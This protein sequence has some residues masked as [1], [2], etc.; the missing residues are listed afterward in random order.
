MTYTIPDIIDESSADISQHDQL[1]RKALVEYLSGVIGRLDGPFVM[2]LDSPFGTGKTTFVHWLKEDLKHKRHQCIYFDAWKVDYAT[3]PLVAMVASI[4]RDFSSEGVDNKYKKQFKKVK[5]VVTA[6]AKSSVVAGTKRLTFDVVDLEVIAKSAEPTTD[7]VTQFNK[8][9]ESLNAFRAEL[10][11]AVKLLPHPTPTADQKAN[12]VF[13][14]DELDRCR[15][16]FAIQLLER[17]KHLFDIENIV[18]ILSIDKKQ[19]E[20]SIKAVYGSEINAPEY[21]RRFFNLEYRLPV[22]D[23]T[24]YI[25]SLI[26]RFNLDPVFA[27]RAEQH[28]SQFRYD[29]EH[30]VTYLNFL[31]NAMGLSLR[32]IERCMTRLRIIMDGVTNNHYLYPVLV[33]LLIVL[34]SNQPDLYDGIISGDTSPEDII[35]HLTSLVRGQLKEEPEEQMIQAIHAYLLI[36]DPDQKR[37]QE[38]S[39]KLEMEAKSCNDSYA[40]LLIG[41]RDFIKRQRGFRNMSLSAIAKQVELVSGI[42]K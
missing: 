22:A 13:F 34:H 24:R 31:A 32:A 2:A 19:I 27:G 29:R 41:M 8:E 10:T 1:E 37:A 28:P 12:L 39:E 25:D 26:T 40:A 30:I 33:V 15:P 18:F 3:D 21:L 35:Q 7:I 11:E 16:T 6:L 14:V 17:V 36:V 9:F 23:T 38:Q 5:D 42:R 20:A 4:D